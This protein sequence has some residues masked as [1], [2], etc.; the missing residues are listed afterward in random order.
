MVLEDINVHF[1]AAASYWDKQ[2]RTAHNRKMLSDTRKVHSAGS[3]FLVEDFQSF[4]N[5]RKRKTQDTPG[6]PSKI[7]DHPL[8]DVEDDRIPDELT[9]DEQL[10]FTFI[11]KEQRAKSKSLGSHRILVANVPPELAKICP[12][13]QN[14][15]QIEPVRRMPGQIDHTLVA[16]AATMVL[17]TGAAGGIAYL[18][19]QTGRSLNLDQDDEVLQ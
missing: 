9:A 10:I 12:E 11:T 17:Q 6:E 7:A 1:A 16:E 19:K 13:L 2:E 18:Q 15:L 8:A 5:L 3:N 14:T 4:V